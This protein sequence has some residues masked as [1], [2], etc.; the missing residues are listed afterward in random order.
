MSIITK[1][2]HILELGIRGSLFLKA[3]AISPSR[4]NIIRSFYFAYPS[5]W[6]SIIKEVLEDPSSMGSV[7]ALYQLVFL[8][9]LPLE[10]ISVQMNVVTESQSCPLCDAILGRYLLTIPSIVPLAEM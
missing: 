8:D 7:I 4:S 1:K 5:T 2:S 6:N 9:R 10:L 3:A